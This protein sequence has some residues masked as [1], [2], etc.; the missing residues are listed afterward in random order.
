MDSMAF[1]N[2]TQICTDLALVSCG[3]SWPLNVPLAVC[4]HILRNGRGVGLFGKGGEEL[5][6]EMDSD[7]QQQDALD[8]VLLEQQ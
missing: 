4:P 6:G 1:H 7:P 3:A 2:L 5:L 8:A